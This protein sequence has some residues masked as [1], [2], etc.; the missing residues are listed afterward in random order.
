LA[1]A[2]EAGS[3]AAKTAT[4]ASATEKVMRCSSS[5]LHQLRQLEIV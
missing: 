3:A 5:H 4:A 2:A 1:P